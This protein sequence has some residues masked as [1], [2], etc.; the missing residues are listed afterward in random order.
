MGFVIADA[1]LPSGTVTVASVH[2]VYLDWLR[3][4]SRRQE[5]SMVEEVVKSPAVI[6]GDFNQDMSASNVPTY[7]AWAPAEN[8]DWVI[9]KGLQAVLQ[10]LAR[11]TLRPSRCFC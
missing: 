3:H 5:M 6:A 10:T 1:V 2:L 9:A 11:A 4:N 7:P 8:R